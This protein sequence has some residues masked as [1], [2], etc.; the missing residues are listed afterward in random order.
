MGGL[1]KRDGEYVIVADFVE[2]TIMEDY[3]SIKMY[4][5][6]TLLLSIYQQGKLLT[7]LLKTG[8]Q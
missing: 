1:T 5:K 7:H 3:N 8:T 4:R 2:A 6:I